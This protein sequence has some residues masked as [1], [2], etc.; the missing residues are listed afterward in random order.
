ML[1]VTG[2]NSR[3]PWGAL[4]ASVLAH[5]V[6]IVLVLL[7][8][9]DAEPV[10]IFPQAAAEQTRTV[11]LTPLPAAPP[12][13]RTP[14]PPPRVERR[15]Q[16]DRLPLPQVTRGAENIPEDPPTPEPVPVTSPPSPDPGPRSD[17][18]AGPATAPRPTDVAAATPTLESEARRLFGPRSAP[19][20]SGAAPSMP[21]NNGPTEPRDN[22]CRPRPRPPRPEGQ[23]I[24]LEFV[25]GW[26]YNDATHVPLAG[27]HLQIMGTG[28]STF[29]DDHGHYRLGFDASL[30]DECRSQYVRVIASGV[31]PQLIV[32][33]RGVGG[34]DIYLRP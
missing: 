28:Y 24:T 19:S 1:P 11:V 20:G 17:A 2:R 25:E 7:L 4:V 29:A 10:R 14:P 23:P 32:L 22:D 21:W 6:V 26:V 34:T 13:R 30:V 9:R 8:T 33:G 31:P 18:V 3:K 16:Q 27:A 5:V 12:P 15:R